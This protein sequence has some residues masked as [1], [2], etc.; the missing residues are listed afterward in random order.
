MGCLISYVFVIGELAL[1]HLPLAEKLTNLPHQLLVLGQHRL[2]GL[3]VGVEIGGGH[4]LLDVFD[5][6][7]AVRDA[8]LNCRDAI[9]QRLEGA[10]APFLFSRLLLACFV[11]L[12][13]VLGLG[14]WVLGLRSWVLRLDF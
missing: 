11:G 6:L 8:A 9:F 13:W 5:G 3:V 12:T 1:E 2:R 7:F 10:L 14:S 4:L